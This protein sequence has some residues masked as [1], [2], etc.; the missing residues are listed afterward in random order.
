[1]PSE[2][3]P[4]RE[5]LGVD[6]PGQTP[7]Y[8]ELLG[9][10]DFE[11][12]PEALW[13]AAYQRRALLRAQQYGDQPDL[14]KRLL[15]EVDAAEAC[16]LNPGR[17]TDYDR[18]LRAGEAPPLS[19]ASSSTSSSKNE[20]KAGGGSKSPRERRLKPG[21]KEVSAKEVS[22]KAPTETSQASSTAE[23]PP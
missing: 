1:M 16:L 18:A 22:A 2:L 8:H 19:K 3:N 15:E 9:V 20:E 23:T 14:A 13:A 12:N 17:K 5:W 4:Y 7:N 10:A 21:G 6:V 11:A